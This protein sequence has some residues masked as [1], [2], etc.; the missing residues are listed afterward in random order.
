M[1]TKYLCEVN[2]TSKNIVVYHNKK[3]DFWFLAVSVLMK[4]GLLSN[5]FKTFQDLEFEIGSELTIIKE[6]K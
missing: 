4:K 2:N 6:I 3:S 1:I 5:Y